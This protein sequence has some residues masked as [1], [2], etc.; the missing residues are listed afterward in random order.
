MSCYPQLPSVS[1]INVAVGF[2]VAW[3]PKPYYLLSA[4]ALIGFTINASAPCRQAHVG[5]LGAW[6]CHCK[7]GGSEPKAIGFACLQTPPWGKCPSWLW[8]AGQGRETQLTL[9]TLSKPKF[10]AI[11]TS[12]AL[13]LAFSFSLGIC[14]IWGAGSSMWEPLFCTGGKLGFFREPCLVPPPFFSFLNLCKRLWPPS[15]PGMPEGCHSSSWA[16][17]YKAS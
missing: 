11:P 6:L 9:P 16:Q 10:F 3:S 7:G 4:L 1:F 15:S 5:L 8:G 2:L 12:P 14:T 13:L 17:G